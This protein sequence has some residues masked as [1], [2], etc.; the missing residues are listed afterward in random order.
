MRAGSGLR[1]AHAAVLAAVCVV[2]SGTG[3]ALASGASPP[4]AAYAVAVPPVCLLAWRLA[5]KERSAGV[6]VSVSAAVQVLLH[7]LFAAVP[8][9]GSGGSHHGAGHGGAGALAGPGGESGPPSPLSFLP[10]LPSGTVS[11]TLPD[12]VPAIASAIT[13]AI[14][15]AISSVTG[16]AIGSG[17]ASGLAPGMT[18]AHLAAGAV[19]GWWLWRGERALAQSALALRLFLRGRLRFVRAVF[20]GAYAALPPENLRVSRPRRHRVRLP[21]SLLLLRAVTRRGPPL[22]PS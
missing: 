12:T 3:H 1:I 21:E 10:P 11:G 18:A 16:P 13:S 14:A 4:P 8:H 2:V 20:R 6:V 17:P 22:L 9:G 19:C 15:S 5:R 7:L